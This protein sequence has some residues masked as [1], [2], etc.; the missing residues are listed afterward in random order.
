MH[1]CYFNEY[2]TMLS[3]F[4]DQNLGLRIFAKIS[5]FQVNPDIFQI[6]LKILQNHCRFHMD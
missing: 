2:N 1:S 6:P 5:N 4:K 3:L